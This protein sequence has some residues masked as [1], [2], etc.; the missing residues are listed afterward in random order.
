M[1]ALIALLLLVA[2]AADAGGVYT[3]TDEHGVVHYTDRPIGPKQAEQVKGMDIGPEAASKP[4]NIRVSAEALQGTWCAFELVSTAGAGSNIAERIEW[5]FTGGTL[6]YL[7]LDSKLK[8]NSKFK[9]DDGS[10]TTDQAAMGN[11]R[12][13]RFGDDQMELGG[14]GIYT[15]LRRGNC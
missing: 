12:I 8:I 15:R 11:H 10:I 9:L 6:Q 2:S 3:W 14:D 7:D 5:T 13:R 1:R 4:R